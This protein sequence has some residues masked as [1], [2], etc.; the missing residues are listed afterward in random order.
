M[1]A[2][3]FK[4]ILSEHETLHG[5]GVSVTAYYASLTFKLKKNCPLKSD[6]LLIFIYKILFNNYLILILLN[7]IKLHVAQTCK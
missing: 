1:S 6:K 4:G 5:L 2:D 3:L 7:V